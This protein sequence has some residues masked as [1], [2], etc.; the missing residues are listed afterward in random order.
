MGAI[1]PFQ[2]RRLGDGSG[3]RLPLKRGFEVLLLTTR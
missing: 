1:T 2:G 3:A